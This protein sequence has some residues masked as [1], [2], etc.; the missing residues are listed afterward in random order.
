MAKGAAPVSP[1]APAAGFPELP[2]VAGVRFAAAAAGVR[3]AGRLDV[4]LAQLAAGSAVAGVFTRSAT[5]SAP[6]LWCEACLAALPGRRTDA[7]FA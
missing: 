3:Y 2:A 7:G 4:M 1:L 5:R 6:V